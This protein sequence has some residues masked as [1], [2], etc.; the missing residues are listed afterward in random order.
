MNNISPELA[1]ELSKIIGAK[2]YIPKT[3]SENVERL[4]KIYQDLY[5]QN[6]KDEFDLIAQF[7]LD[8]G[9]S[10]IKTFLFK[11]TDV[12]TKNHKNLTWYKEYDEEACKNQT[13]NIKTEMNFKK[14]WYNDKKNIGNKYISFDI[15][16]ASFG[17]LKLMSQ[18]HENNI[19]LDIQWSEYLKSM[20]PTDIRGNGIETDIPEI[21]YKSKYVRIRAMNNLRKLKF[22]WEL[23]AVKLCAYLC[24]C[25]ISRDN[26]F[27][28]GDEVVV[29]IENDEQENLIIERA[30]THNRIDFFRQIIFHLEEVNDIPKPNKHSIILKV[31]DFPIDTRSV[32]LNVPDYLYDILHNK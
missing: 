9:R 16:G 19:P 5:K 13:I 10:H 28:Q 14:R 25:N 4:E 3:I 21:V 24:E 8:S 26:F 17:S 29:H 11:L 30:K 27:V 18:D 20:V 6:K 23:E 2:V 1:L 12:I 31:I 15:K 22:L 7:M 32:L